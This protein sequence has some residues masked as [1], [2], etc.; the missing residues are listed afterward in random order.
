MGGD[1]PGGGDGW[2][3]EFQAGSLVQGQA[4][5]VMCILRV[6]TCGPPA[7]I[8]LAEQVQ[9]LSLCINPDASIGCATKQLSSY[10][11]SREMT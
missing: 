3:R 1:S 6:V 11:L 2:G 7:R 4:G 8:R 10:F 5:G 9:N